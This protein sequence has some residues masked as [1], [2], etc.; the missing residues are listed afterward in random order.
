MNQEFILKSGFLHQ[1]T[2][3]CLGYKIFMVV[4]CAN[5]TNQYTHSIVLH[6]SELYSL[7]IIV[8]FPKIIALQLTLLVD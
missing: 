6:Y 1:N 7:K 4:G 3:N 5:D 2:L 8:A